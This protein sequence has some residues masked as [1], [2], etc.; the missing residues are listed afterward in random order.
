M[1]R[2][3]LAKGTAGEI[4]PVQFLDGA[5]LAADR[6]ANLMQRGKR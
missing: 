5:T 2:E 6:L 4:Q 3:M 1:M